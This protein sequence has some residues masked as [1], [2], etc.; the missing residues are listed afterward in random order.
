MKILFKR[1][2][3]DGSITDKHYAHIYSR[4]ASLEKIKLYRMLTAIPR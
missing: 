1:K 4:Y 2:I 3:F